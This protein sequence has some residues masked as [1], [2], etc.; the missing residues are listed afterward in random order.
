MD[1]DG[2]ELDFDILSASWRSMSDADAYGEMLGAWDRKL[3]AVA[4]APRFPLVDGLLKRQLSSINDLLDDRRHMKL[5]DP[6]DI[7]VT[8][9]PAPA[10]VLSPQGMVAVH[11]EGAVS[12]FGVRQGARAG[13]DWLRDESLADYRA[14]RSSG[15]G[16]G[17]VDYAIVRT[18][19]GEKH[20]ALAEVFQL[21]VEGQSAP[22]TVVRSLEID[23]LPNVT[24]ALRKV[25]GMTKAEAEVCRM[26]FVFGDHRAVARERGV[27][28]ETVR[29]QIKRIL[30][31]AEVHSMAELMRLLA[32][33][34]ARAAVHHEHRD[35]S[36]SD[37]DGREAIF[38]RRDG[39][40]LAYSWIGAEDGR[41][42]LFLPGQTSFCFL[43]AMIC[44]RLEEEGIK[45]LR[46]SLPG[47]G[48]SEPCAGR[49]Q[50]TDGCEA[51]EEF[52]DAMVQKP[53]PALTSRGGQ[54]YL[55]NLA[56]WRPDL[57]SM[58][59]CVS[60]AWNVTPKRVANLPLGQRT[61]VKLATDA[62]LAFD[63]ACK[64]GYHK[65]RQHGPDFYVPLGYGDSD[66]DKASACD[67]EVLPLL[68]ASIR[69]MLAQ[70]H[71]A[72]RLEQEMC[73]KNH[74]PGMVRQLRVPIHYLVPGEIGGIT[75][76]DLTQ[77]RALNSGISLEF[78]PNTGELIPFQQ[79]ELFVQ[80]LVS[81]ASDNPSEALARYDGMG[82]PASPE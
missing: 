34:C 33:L 40:K 73:A 57:F 61:F 70:G 75:P 43:P 51:L 44:E 29:T 2:R 37:P 46:V 45:L 28:L 76:D 41:P 24:A 20:D 32:L 48:N 18:V 38:T 13:T 5:E 79:P 16:N 65:L 11:N 3:S 49:D 53:I 82:M 68:R 77:V 26:L 81:L 6:L 66:A 15:L 63:L 17:N 1:D 7:A 10:M 21:E 69:H 72:F 56:R 42:V 74:F 67:P 23:W 58:L 60:L 47:H 25:F 36:W 31:K 80:R 71:D 12:H 35:L 14:V 19:L 9:T 62:P 22:Y 39:R 8:E 4:K 54:F 59:M 30:G 52:C 64:L 55:V 50:L 78:V 27:S